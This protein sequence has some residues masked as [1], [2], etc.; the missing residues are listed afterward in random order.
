MAP[1]YAYAD[2]VKMAIER[3]NESFRWME[4]SY[5]GEFEE[6]FRSSKCRT[7]PILIKRD[8]KEVEDESRTNVAMPD[9]AVMIRRN[10]ARL[11][12]NPPRMNYLCNADES[13]VPEPEMVAEK[14]TGWSFMQYDRTGE[15]FTQRMNVQQCETF[16]FSATKTYWDTVES[17][18]QFR[19]KRTSITDREQMLKL[20]GMMPDEI[21]RT[22]RRMGQDISEV[23]M[24]QMVAEQGDELKAKVPRKKYEGP[25]SKHIFIGDLFLE[26]G[27]RTL[28]ESAWCI[29]QYTQNVTWLEYWLDRTYDDPFDPSKKN[30]PVFDPKACQDLIDSG[31]ESSTL[32]K[33]GQ[34]SLRN[35]LRFTMGQ[36][37]EPFFDFRLIPG[38]RFHIMEEHIIR[39]GWGWIRWIGNEKFLLGEMPYPWDLYGKYIYSDYVALPD[40]VVGIGDCTPRLGRFLVKLHNVS[41][42]QRQDL[43]T[44]LL[45]RIV[46]RQH[47]ADLPDEAIDRGPFRVID[48]KSLKD[49][50]IVEE[51]DVP[52]SAWE[53]EAQLLRMLGIL[54]PVMTNIETGTNVNPQAGRTAT[55]SVL[56]ARSSDA[57]LQ[58]KLDGYSLHLKS[59]G[60]KKLWMLQQALQEPTT[61][62]AKYIKTDGLTQRYGTTARIS[63]DPYEMQEDFEVEPENGSTLSVDDEW[64]RMAV[65]RLYQVAAT[66]P[67][68]WDK[69]KVAKEYAKTIRGV[70]ARELILPPAPPAPVPPRF[71][72]AVSAKY[73]DLDNGTKMALIK[74][75]LP[76]AQVNP[77][78]IAAQSQLDGVIKTGEAA[79]AA[80]TI[81]SPGEHDQKLQQTAVQGA[82]DAHEG[83]AQR[84]HDHLIGN[85]DRNAAAAANNVARIDDETADLKTMAGNAGTS[86]SPSGE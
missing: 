34:N 41:V 16:G 17:I 38:K 84:L 18:R 52:Q 2:P 53:T 24:T 28:D 66:D 3:R 65:E 47:G 72:F 68:V 60:E 11:T 10:A 30:I 27:F 85:A 42:G 48:V 37:T 71:S 35:R 12:A 75:A 40:L 56:Q 51:P 44:N 36:V 14:L 25:V 21:R 74:E 57:M 5:Y 55:G 79:K 20:T 78:E 73:G 29:E 45:K 82:V 61:I 69:Y 64:R 50:Q 33:E 9:T 8:G 49:F 15:A 70:E 23:E 32:S 77:Q 31:M 22:I 58:Y 76:Q 26:P 62:P 6:V 46:L 7:E 4:N 13:L 81:L 54:E 86:K 43:I 67:T 80:D 63:L 39:D 1:E 19:F 59:T 83:N